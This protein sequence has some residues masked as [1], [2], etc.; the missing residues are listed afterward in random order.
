MTNQ[1]AAG[2]ANPL[3]A[4]PQVSADSAWP[5]ERWSRGAVDPGV[6]GV[7]TPLLDEGFESEIH[8]Q[9]LAV[10]VVQHGRIVYERYG[11]DVSAEDTL[12]SWS[13]AKSMTHTLVGMATLDG[14]VD[15]DLPLGAPEWS[16]DD[17]RR[18]ITAR[19]LLAMRSG[20]AWNEE[21][22]DAGV[23]DVIEMLFGEAQADMAHFAASKPLAEPI[24]TVFNYSSGTTNVVARWLGDAIATDGTTMADFMQRRLFDRLGMASATAKFDGSGTFVGSSF[25]YANATD[26]AR[27]GLL[28]LRDG[29]WRDGRC[30]PTGWMD[31]ARRTRSVDPEEPLGYG[32]HFWTRL[33][34]PH[35]VFWASGYEGQIIAMIPKADAVLVRLG[36]TT[37]PDKPALRR[38]FNQVVDTLSDAAPDDRAVTP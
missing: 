35:G 6:A 19:D 18:H 5:G 20:L 26:F 38:W 30:V 21:Y 31:D 11:L 29:V 4:L 34:D 8:G 24:D 3:V 9:T 2:S 33:D 16:A 10:V 14:S 15:V 13:M 32:E 36:K 7:L 22:V 37:E 23:S 27:Y 25:V 12:I 28:C 17:P 1:S